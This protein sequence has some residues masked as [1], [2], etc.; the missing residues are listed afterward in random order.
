[1]E[2]DG[3]E[4]GGNGQVD[5]S[6]RMKSRRV[7]TASKRKSTAAVVEDPFS[8]LARSMKGEV[9]SSKHEPPS[10]SNSKVAQAIS[11]IE[12]ATPNGGVDVVIQRLRDVIEE[13]KEKSRNEAM[14][15]LHGCMKQIQ[16][17]VDDYRAAVRRGITD[18]QRCAESDVD[19]LKQSEERIHAN[20]EATVR[21][22]NETLQAAKTVREALR[23]QTGAV[24]MDLR[25]VLDEH[26]AEEEALVRR[27]RSTAL[28]T[29]SAF[30]AKKMAE[31]P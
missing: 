16:Q 22:L 6:S 13:N 2:T 21:S 5:S 9:A 12:N 8:P 1:M 20:V 10:S 27:L 31:V 23:E 30:I 17:L 19:Q 24:E 26:I 7:E 3:P 11:S 15:D 4:R 29:L 28:G 25:R 14:V 18:F